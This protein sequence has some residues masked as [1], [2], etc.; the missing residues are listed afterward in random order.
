VPFVPASGVA[1]VELIFLYQGQRIENV[2]HIQAQPS[3]PLPESALDSANT[4][5]DAWWKGSMRGHTTAGAVLQQIEVRDMTVAD[6]LAKIY[7]CLVN[8]AGTQAGGINMPGNVTVAVKWGTG[9]AGRSRRGRTFHIG[10][11][12]VYSAGNV[13]TVG[14][15]TALQIGYDALRTQ[16]NSA[17]TPLVI[18]SRVSNYVYRSAALITPVT[19]CSVEINLDSMRRRLTGPGRGD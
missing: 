1:R 12:G 19:S 13:L 7:P 9:Y 3:G 10:L 11:N 18:Y 17:G 8:C 15:Q 14:A 2:F 16:L 5:F 6:G 4:R